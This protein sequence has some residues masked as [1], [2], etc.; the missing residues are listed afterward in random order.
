MIVYRV[1][2]YD[3]HAAHAESGHPDH[4]FHPQGQGRVDNPALYDVWYFATAPEAAIGEVRGDIPIWSDDIFRTPFLPS[5]RLALGTFRLPDDL[6]I[7]DLDDARSLLDRGLRPTQ[8]IARNRPTTQAWAAQIFAEQNSGGT[9]RWAGIR[10]WSYQRPH[11]TVLALW[12]PHGDPVW[13]TFLEATPLHVTDAP[14][15]DAAASLGRPI[16]TA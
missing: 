3:T 9:R 1:F 5:G 7:L 11:W 13:H 16:E 2:A 15:Q 6:P 10:W 4:L 14:V 12:V 8:V